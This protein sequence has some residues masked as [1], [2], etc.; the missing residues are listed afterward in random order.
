MDFL[1][2]FSSNTIAFDVTYLLPGQ[3]HHL[4]N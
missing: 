1:M 3:T 2:F 4:S